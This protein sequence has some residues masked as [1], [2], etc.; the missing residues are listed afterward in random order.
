M[1][2]VLEGQ[3]ATHR[4]VEPPRMF[5][6]DLSGWTSVNGGTT[7]GLPPTGTDGAPPPEG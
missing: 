3:R 7:T 2:W 4:L 5:V 6:L 1:E